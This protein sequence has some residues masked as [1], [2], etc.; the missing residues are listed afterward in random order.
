MAAPGIS[1]GRRRPGIILKSVACGVVAISCLLG[2]PVVAQ[3]SLAVRALVDICLPYA[4]RSLSFEKSIRAARNLEFRRPFDDRAPL[5]EWASEIELIS[6]DG[7]WRIRIAE[8]SREDEETPVY[9]VSCSISSRHASARELG[10]FGRRAFNDPTLWTLA[11]DN[12]WRWERRTRR[13]Q[14][15]RL[16]VEVTE[17]A[18]QLPT[19][20]V[21]GLYY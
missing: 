6:S 13:P 9:A 11:P 2:T 1:G 21:T 5:D 16:S 15:Y 3:D 19:M 14:E 20:T 7:N 12:R 8:G 17:P 18:E 4:T 10:D